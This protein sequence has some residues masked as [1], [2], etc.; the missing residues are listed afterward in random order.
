MLATLA[1]SARWLVA[2][3]LLIAG[4]AKLR[5]GEWQ[6]QARAVR[7]YGLRGDL[8]IEVVAR[9]LPWLELSLGIALAAGLF[10]SEDAGVVAMMLLI[11]ASL[12]TWHVSHGRSFDCGCGNGPDDHPIGWLTICRNV[13]MAATAAVVGLVP[14]QAPTIYPASPA[15]TNSDE[16]QGVMLTVMLSVIILMSFRLAATALRHST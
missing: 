15:P 13:I 8:P 5:G 14:V 7:N 12:M 10:V 2:L 11:F 9:G 3:E 16:I 6:R 4:A 1:L